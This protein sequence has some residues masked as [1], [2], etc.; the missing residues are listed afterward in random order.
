MTVAEF[1]TRSE[2]LDEPQK[3]GWRGARRCRVRTTY[4][5]RCHRQQ[6]LADRGARHKVRGL[7]GTLER[8]TRKFRN[9]MSRRGSTRRASAEAAYGRTTTG[10]RRAAFADTIGP[11][12]RCTPSGPW[13]V[14][15]I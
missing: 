11:D 15:G 1:E 8:A 7:G 3:L 12:R 6:P 5:L 13:G 2:H 10:R 9:A 14:G 4:K